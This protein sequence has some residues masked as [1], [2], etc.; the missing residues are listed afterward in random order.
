[1][2]TSPHHRPL[3]ST[4]VLALGAAACE[5]APFD[6]A[7]ALAS[8]PT[9]VEQ[10]HDATAAFAAYRGGLQEVEPGRFLV[11]AD[12][13]IGADQLEEHFHR[14]H[15]TD[16]A[17]IVRKANGSR[18]IWS[19]ASRWNLTWC[20][21]DAFGGDKSS[22]VEAME[23]A[24]AGWQTEAGAGVKFARAAAEDANCTTS[25]ANVRIAVIYEAGLSELG[26]ANVGPLSDNGR[27]HNRIKLS[28]KALSWWDL[29]FGS[30]GSLDLKAVVAHELGH[31]LGFYHEHSSPSAGGCYDG[32]NDANHEAVT[33]YDAGSIMHYVWAQDTGCTMTT[34]RW[35]STLDA[36]GAR[37]VYPGGTTPAP[38][39]QNRSYGRGAGTVPSSCSAGKVKEAG[40]CY[41]P[42]AAGYGAAGPVCW[43]RCPAGYTDDGALCR[44]NAH[45]YGNGCRG[46]CAAGYTNDGCTC[47]R[48]AHIFAKR[49]YG[50]GAGTVPNNCGSGKELDAGLCY[51][52]CAAGW[53]G[54]GPVCHE[55]CS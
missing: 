6:G 17:L 29:S 39:C 25:N 14:T 35:I 51:T 4:L 38:I 27:E 15:A 33:A 52:T 45:I 23:K 8:T 5:Q 3:V 44:R 22:V 50:R 54:V 28:K 31:A 12:M 13:V 7:A 55:K 32:S 37:A 30:F 19:E 43:Q 42:C 1:M 53:K 18:V 41:T 21:S 9:Q 26:N 16:N 10:A 34:Y 36:E 46:G 40:L 11:E 49:S 20:V 48:N 47:R 24:T 2:R